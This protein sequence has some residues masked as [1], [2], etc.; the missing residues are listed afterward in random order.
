MVD[1]ADLTSARLVNKDVM[2]G[3]VRE[4][5]PPQDHIGM[6][7]LP[8]QEVQSD[9]VIWDSIKGLT[10]GL[11]PARAMDSESELA[12]KDEVVG[13]G[14]AALIDWSIKDRWNA[15]DVARYREITAFAGDSSLPRS[16]VAL[17]D[18]WEQRMA[19]AAMKRKR[20]LDNRLEWLAWQAIEGTVAYNDGKINFSIDFGI[21][22]GQKNVVPTTTWDQT[23]ADPIGNIIAWR[24]I[25]R[26]TTGVELRRVV[27]SRTVLFNVMNN[28][29]FAQ[30]FA[31]Q[32]P[33][34]AFNNTFGIQQSTQ[35][36]ANATDMEWYVYDAVYRTRPFGS[37][38]FTNTRFNNAKKVY[39]FPGAGEIVNYSGYGNGLGLGAMLTSPHPEGNWTPGF[40]EWEQER[41]DPWGYD[42]GNGIKA[43]PVLWESDVLFNAQVLP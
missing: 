19:R 21:P 5:E 14:K 34:Y 22:A 37:T 7:L 2:L 43:F 16:I 6:S 18:D 4:L 11:A 26:N 30:M 12:Q 8:M 39:L 32:N 3:L 17:T 9:E 35:L 36:L 33:F 25:V 28:S 29:K 27:T 24:E 23:T 1:I 10:A 31:G 38:T 15:S 42:Q 41:R 40:Y 20:Q 13:T